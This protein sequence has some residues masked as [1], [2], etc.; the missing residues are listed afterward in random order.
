[1][2]KR[3]KKKMRGIKLSIRVV[4][5][6]IIVGLLGAGRVSAA[7]PEI[8]TVQAP[9]AD[10]KFAFWISEG[11]PYYRVESNGKVLIEDAKLGLNTSLG[12]LNDGF[13][14]GVPA[15]TE[16][17]TSW[18]PLVGEQETI[19]DCYKQMRIVLTH[20]SGTVLGF[21]VRVYDEGVAF[22]YELPQTEDSYTI[23]DEYT[24]FVFPAGAVAS[25]HT[26]GNQTVPKRM[27]VE[28]FPGGVMQRPMTIQYQDG[29][30]LTIC[31]GNLDNYGVMVLKKDSSQA[32]TIKAGYTSYKPSHLNETKGPDITVSGDGPDATPWRV[33]VIGRDETELMEHASIVMNLNE[34]PDEETYRFSEWVEAG[35]CL[36]AATGMNNTAIKKIVDQAEEHG[37][38]YVLLD[39]GWYGPEYDVNCDPRLDPKKLDS[40]V[41]SD[42]I[43]LDQYFSTE[44]GYDGHGEGVFNTRGVGF[45]VYKDLGTSGNFNTN[46]D[47]PE[48]CQYANAKN[49]GIILYV[50]GVYF[51]DSSGRNRFTTDELFGYFE[52][53]GV[54]GVKPGFVH[55][56]AQ[57]YE[58]YMEHVIAT[59]AKHK[60]VMTIH[61]EYVTTGIER[62][63]PNLMQVEGIL[64]DEGIGKSDP[65]IGEDIA[66]LFTRTVQGPADHT[67]CYP[68]KGTKAYALAS[69]LMFRAGMSVLYWYTNPESVPAQ[70]KGKM[71]L[72]KGMPTNWKKSLYLEG[73]M[74][75]YATFARKSR[76]DVWYVG[77]LSAVE[78]TLRA[79]LEFLDENTWYVADI[80]ADGADADARAGWNSGAKE[81]QTLENVKYLVNRETVLERELK[82]GYGYAVKLTKASEED[83][84]LYEK[85]S[86]YRERL[87]AAVDECRELQ[88]AD[89]TTDTWSVFHEA[90]EAAQNVMEEDGASEEQLQEALKVLENARA[91]LASTKRVTELLAKAQR[92]VS[93]RYI[94]KSWAA[95]D[96]ALKEAEEL[97]EESFTQADLDA[98]ADRIEQAFAGLVKNKNAAVKETIYLSD[99][100]YDKEKSTCGPNNTRPGNIR[101]DKNRAGGALT[102]KVDG[103]RREFTRGMGAD[104]PCDLYFNISG[105]GLDVLEAYVG[106]DAA[107]QD[108]G[109]IVFRVYGDGELLYESAPS[110][111]GANN[112]QFFSIPVSN[113]RELRLEGDMHGSDQGDWADWADAKLMSYVNPDVYLEGLTV[114]G[115]P[116]EGF[117]PGTF[118]YLYPVSEPDQ[119]PLVEAVPVNEGVY[120]AI[121]DAEDIP[122][123]TKVKVRK[124]DGNFQT[125]EILFVEQEGLDYISDLPNDLIVKNTLYNKTVYKNV[126]VKGDKLAITGADG[127]TAMNFDKGI[128]IHACSSTDSEVVY[129]IEGRGYD[130]FEGYAGIRYATHTEEINGASPTGVPRSKINFRIYVDDETAPR[131]E[132]GEMTSRTPAAYYNVDVRGAKTLRIVADACKDQSADHGALCGAR[133]LSYRDIYSI[134]GNVNTGAVSVNQRKIPVELYG[135]NGSLIAETL[136]D[137]EGAYQFEALLAGNYSVRVAA[138]T[139]NQE[140]VL[141]VP[142]TDRN[143]TGLEINLAPLQYSISILPLEKAKVTVDK[144]SAAAGETV[145]V[146]VGEIAQDK[147]FLSIE[148]TGDSGE[149]LELTSAGTETERSYTFTMPKQSVRVKAELKDNEV[150]QAAL[151]KAQEIDAKILAIGEVT[152]AKKAEIESVR[153][154]YEALN[155]LEKSQVKELLRLELSEYKWNILDLERQAEEAKQAAEDAERRAQEEA[156]KAKNEADRAKAEAD[157]AKTES[158]KA[159]TEA[160]KAKAEADKAKTEADKAETEAEKARTE[161]EKARTEA[162]KAEAEAEKAKAQAGQSEQKA[163]EAAEAEQR[164]QEAAQEAERKA[165]EAEQ[166]AQ[167]AAQKVQEA[168]QKVREA[169]QKAQ[170]AAEAEKKAVEAE[171]K[172]QEAAQAAKEDSRKEAEEQNRKAEEL[173]R[174]AQR[175]QQQAEELQKQAEESMQKAAFRGEKAAVSKAVS[176]KKKQARI[177]WKK[178]EGAEGYVIQYA[179]KRSFKGAKKV[180]VNQKTSFI[181]RKLKGRRTYYVKVTGFRNIGGE[182]IYTQ[183]SAR[184]KV[185]VK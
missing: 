84:A 40:D 96:K 57:D 7:E 94:A 136:T 27:S 87:K 103:S 179:A 131:F 101:K 173:L 19:Q 86:V 100:D 43:L 63:Y 42:K 5:M 125:Y 117:Q 6:V 147:E 1:M 153:A 51:P 178:I 158:D 89:Y 88:E 28:S 65:Q 74:Y 163:Q 166:K 169:E 93:Y 47:I 29:Q 107:K 120:Y 33:L 79:P 108:M 176:K 80:Y 159:K 162:G 154:E 76:E 146:S 60:L 99:L 130:R 121:E 174:Q 73:K 102:L 35:S 129:N 23:S 123:R 182:M 32:R 183:A 167:A 155:D 8:S 53:W 171:Q 20:S 10:L 160:D 126:S 95:L 56:R 34:E 68:G 52:K 184:K 144:E 185:R 118:Q 152:L 175:L 140:S 98:A 149:V 114:D 77:S 105:L 25:V 26:P 109:D 55:V 36:R 48:L 135:E 58:K 54:K 91:Q 127:S 148:V 12:E 150:F 145:T 142:V 67:F 172:A 97:L 141:Q 81:K 82:Y 119:I 132:S 164:A 41:E 104:A 90:L 111:T 3:I 11:V 64:G 78:R 112:A 38:K 18:N 39:T 14:A 168:E 50:N 138:G 177:T 113:V 116:L 157:K 92:Y 61:D 70:D 69:P 13:T 110:G 21:T 22:R 122:G 139:E 180:I 134:S 156:G 15:F 46:V 85:Y 170:A 137:A 71:D 30:V 37:F 2:K 124:R 133:F 24:Q 16:S 59:A 9:T 31:E 17:D 115:E 4:A 49:V 72:W 165:Q 181:I 83:M 75:E 62:T 151:R 128:G 143:I 161:A 44:G 45:D 66:T 106:V